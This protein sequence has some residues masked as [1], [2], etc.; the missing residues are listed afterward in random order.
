MKIIRTVTEMQNTSLKLKRDGNTIGFVPT[1]GFLHEGHLSLIR[2]A[3]G[4][5]DIL[6]VSIY[7][8]PTQ[9][10]PGEDIDKYPRDIDRDERLCEEEGVDII[11]YPTDEEM[12][13]E[14]Y[15][16]E[17]R[18]KRLGEILC[19]VSRPTH[20][21]GVTTIVSKLFNIVMPDIA[22]FGQKDAQ[23]AV[24][25]R[26]MTLDL[27]FPVKII[28]S[29]TVRESDGLAMSS[30]NAYL[31]EKER[32]IAPALYR[33]LCLAEKMIKSGKGYDAI[34]IIVKMRK[35]ILTAGPFDIDYIEIVD[36]ETLEP[37]ENPAGKDVLIALAARLGKT[38]LIDN[39]IVGKSK[40]KLK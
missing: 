39:I 19:G 33:S 22:V 35:S 34:E 5:C 31:S 4:E 28:V 26:R 15:L 16:T 10:A 29:P 17:V 40:S 8:N 11:F 6:V 30:R 27:N 14:G 24:I 25:I 20:F 37:V 2:R 13:P 18:V 12:Y 21:A 9:F 1:M 38:R 3:R 32:E 36:A 23:Q 7:V